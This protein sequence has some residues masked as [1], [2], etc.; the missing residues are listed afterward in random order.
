MR[1]K[2]LV[3]SIQVV[4]VSSSPSPPPPPPPWL[5]LTSVDITGLSTHGEAS[6]DSVAFCF[7]ELDFLFKWVFQ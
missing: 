5:P 7:L 2:K 1:A 3:S 4:V 6:T